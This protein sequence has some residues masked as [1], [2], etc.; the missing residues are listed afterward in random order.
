M[1]SHKEE[2]NPFGSKEE[3]RED[4]MVMKTMIDK[5]YREL[6]KY[7]KGCLLKKVEDEDSEMTP[8]SSHS[9]HSLGDFEKQ[10][11]SVGLGLL[12]KMGYEEKSLGIHGQGII[13]PLKVKVRPHYARL[14]YGERECSKAMEVRNSPKDEPLQEQPMRSNGTSL[15]GSGK[16][17]KMSKRRIKTNYPHH[18]YTKDNHQRYNKPNYSNVSFHYKKIESEKILWYRKL[19]TFSGLNNHIV[20]KFWKRMP[21]YKKVML[22]RKGIQHEYP[23]PSQKKEKGKKG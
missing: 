8:H 19:C 11:Q 18:V 17:C 7:G 2:Q 12:T 14:G 23:S 15:L 3:F 22:T 10:S 6:K 21:L 20:A 13:E 16:A 4:F 1:S 9:P 5:I